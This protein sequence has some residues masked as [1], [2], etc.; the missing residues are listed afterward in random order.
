MSEFEANPE[1]GLR[2]EQVEVETNLV[3]LNEKFSALQLGD[4]A[5]KRTEREQENI[6]ALAKYSKQRLFDILVELGD[7]TEISNRLEAEIYSQKQGYGKEESEYLFIEIIFE[8][9]FGKELESAEIHPDVKKVVM[10][11]KKE[12][13]ISSFENDESEP[14]RTETDPES[15]EK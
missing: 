10:N 5:D 14:E 9:V 13:D 2:A 11:V 1:A 12:Q 8:E 15:I 4:Y 6:M 3:N 7:I